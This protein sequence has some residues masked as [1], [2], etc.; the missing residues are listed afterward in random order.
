MFSLCLCGERI[1]VTEKELFTAICRKAPAIVPL[2]A[3][4]WWLDAV[5]DDPDEWD[6][7]LTMKGDQVTGVWP[8]LRTERL[9]I[10]MMRNPRLTPYLGPHVFYPPDI[11]GAR[12]DSY[13]YEVSE[14]LLDSLPEADVW[15][16]SLPPGYRQ[17][18]LF[19]RF[20]LRLD[21]QQ[22][23]L[24]PLPD[25]EENIFIG[26][27]EPLRRNLRAAEKEI[28]IVEDPTQLHALFD[29]QK[30]TLEEK[31][32]RQA[33]TEEHM[34]RLM[35]ACL[36][37]ESGTLYLAYENGQLQA[38]IWNVWDEHRSY[39]LM[40][41]KNPESDNYRAMSALLWHCI[42]KARAR[43]NRVFDF[44]GSMDGGVE[45]FFRSFGARR[46][47]YLVLRRD[48]HWLWRLLGAL[49]LR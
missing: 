42:R 3:Q 19:R 6:V 21:V 43:G 39:Y 14:Q 26:F 7:V 22:T 31:R 49:R 5:C 48:D 4:Y 30:A 44:E 16:L 29:F 17:A 9:S 10:S 20:G 13:E 28:R 23:F 32:V 41:G 2:F 11:K 27:K 37:H 34:Q 18:G 1:P 40:G 36:R 12:R 38:A 8:Y 24:L 35:N 46:D 47:L 15:R 45:R 25:E 33:Y